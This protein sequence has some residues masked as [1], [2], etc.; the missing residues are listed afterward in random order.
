MADDVDVVVDT[1]NLVHIITQLELGGAQLATLFEVAH[2]RF[3]TGRRFLFYGPGGLLDA[4]T[5]ALE[6]VTCIQILGLQRPIAP[7]ADSL[8]LAEV[9]RTLRRLRREEPRARWLV[10][11][12]SSKAGILGR[13]AARLAGVD[14]VVHSI[15]GFGHHRYEG[16]IVYHTLLSAEQLTAHVTDGLTAD[17]RSNLDQ[18]YAQAI[19]DRSL[20][21]VVVRC[22]IDVE[23]FR[24]PRTDPKAV[25]ES[26]AIPDDHRVV[27]SLSCLK[28]QKD[29]ETYVRVA[30]Q[31]L[32]ERPQTT[33]LLA[34]DGELRPVVEGLCRDLGLGRSFR[35]LGW[36]RDVADL[37]HASDLLVL[38]SLWEGLPQ[39]FAQAMAAGLPIVA[40]AVDGAAEAVAHGDNGLLAPAGN[41]IELAHDI[42]GLLA[43][44]ARRR[45]MGARGRERVEAFSREQML[46]DLDR[47]YREIAERPGRGLGPRALLACRQLTSRLGL[48]QRRRAGI[49]QPEQDGDEQR[50]ENAEDH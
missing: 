39:V 14:R 5:A 37:L 31:V 43:N 6:D 30:A 36:R 42:L 32:K 18:A 28:P 3:P 15:H 46:E 47:F 17:S 38:T 50:R 23:A 2:S 27:L 20:P 19:V 29:P 33:F 7:T 49:K 13:W 44:D 35:L 12:H 16:R 8:A 25:R 26:L 11:T 10:H 1:W 21:G 41:V 34:G 22:G 40:T 4:E 9:W 45:A 48:A 24:R